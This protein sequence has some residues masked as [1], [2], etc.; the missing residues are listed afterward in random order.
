MSSSTNDTVQGPSSRQV[1]LDSFAS[2]ILTQ[3]ERLEELGRSFEACERRVK[4]HTIQVTQSDELIAE[5]TKT[6]DQLNRQLIELTKRF[7]STSQSLHEANTRRT[8]SARLVRVNQGYCDTFQREI[9]DREKRL[10]ATEQQRDK[11]RQEKLAAS[12]SATSAPDRGSIASLP[13]AT[14]SWQQLSE[15]R[16]PKPARTDADP[17][18]RHWQ[19]QS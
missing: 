10:E 12:N 8:E 16:S 4:N 3:K 2:R 18:I 5:E 13:D 15:L 1:T 7:E 19:Y 6:L 17:D 11:L 9:E 14:G